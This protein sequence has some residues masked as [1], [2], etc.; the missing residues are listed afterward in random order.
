MEPAREDTQDLRWVSPCSTHPTLWL[1]FQAEGPEQT[2]DSICFVP[3]AS[4]VRS[5]PP[6]AG[7]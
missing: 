4:A 6:H 5:M 2:V 1:G 3:M 7:I